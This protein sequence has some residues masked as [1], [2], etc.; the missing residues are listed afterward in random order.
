MPDQWMSTDDHAPAMTLKI[1]GAGSDEKPPVKSPSGDWQ[2]TDGS[3]TKEEPPEKESFIGGAWKNMN[4][5]PILKSIY[6]SATKPPSGVA[7]AVLGPVGST[8]V[9]LAKK[10]IPAILEK[11]K[12]Q[13]DKAKEA[14]DKGDHVEAAGHI[15]AAALPVMGPAAAEAGETIGGA[16]PVF[17]KYGKEITPAKEPNLAGGIGEATGLLAPFALKPAIG[18]ARTVAQ[19][20]GVPELLT[21]SANKTMGQV[22]NATTKGNKIR[23][24]E[25]APELVDRG[26]TAF[27]LKGLKNKAVGQINQ[28]GQAIGDAWDNLPAGTKVEATPVFDQIQKSIDDTHTILDSSG[29]SIPKG[30]EAARAIKNSTALQETLLDVAEQNPT[31]GQLEIPVE[32]LRALRQYFDTVSKQAGRFDGAALKD[33]STAAAHGMAADAIREELGKTFPDIAKLNKEYSFWKNVDQVVGDTLLRKQGQSTPLTKQLLGTAGAAAGYGSGGLKGAVIGKN[34]MEMLQEAASSP[35]WRTYSAVFKD[36]LAKAIS[37]GNKG[38]I[39]FY[40]NQISN[41]MKSARVASPVE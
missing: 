18:A 36:R 17:D 41:A 29:K 6:E 30:P 25:V 28:L 3:A 15:L 23:S 4:P 2:T 12:E 19:S 40:A 10:H 13:Y 16:P 21:E 8:I 37:S 20:S 32:K 9:D 33:Q 38:A 14:W 34:A 31:T 22:L 27:S 5:L 11:Q 7:D 24:A 35:A 1:T 39:N 26:V